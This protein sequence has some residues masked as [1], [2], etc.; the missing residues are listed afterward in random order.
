MP[1][2]RPE[3]HKQKESPPTEF[4]GSAWE[5]Q[6]TN[7]RRQREGGAGSVLHFRL[8]QHQVDGLAGNGRKPKP[9]NNPC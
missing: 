9:L 4:P 8:L 5:W 1:P 6:S 2:I 3:N 7:V